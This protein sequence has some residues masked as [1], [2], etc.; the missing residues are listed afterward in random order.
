MLYAIIESDL[1][2]IIKRQ[3]FANKELYY[4]QV[5]LIV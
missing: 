5:Q 4:I 1:H 2:L 3:W